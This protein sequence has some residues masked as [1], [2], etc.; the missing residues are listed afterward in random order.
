MSQKSKKGLGRGLSALFGDQK[1]EENQPFKQ[2][3]KKIPIAN[4]SRNKFQPRLIF[5]EL[6]LDELASSIKKKWCY[7]TNSS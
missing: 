1:N 3:I 2:S 7:S 6:K 5:D 4:I